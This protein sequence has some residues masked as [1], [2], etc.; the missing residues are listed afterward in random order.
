[1]DPRTGAAGSQHPNHQRIIQALINANLLRIRDTPGEDESQF[2]E[3]G[4][5]KR[6]GV[7][8]PKSYRVGISWGYELHELTIPVRQWARIVGGVEISMTSRGWY[9]GKSFPITW[10]FNSYEVQSLYVTY[11]DDGGVGYEGNLYDLLI[12]ESTPA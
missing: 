10:S 11:G 2:E 4:A 12:D 8:L 9:E 1:M 7:E 5:R 3:T 6:Y